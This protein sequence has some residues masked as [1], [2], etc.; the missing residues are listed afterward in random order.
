MKPDSRLKFDPSATSSTL[1]DQNDGLLADDF[2]YLEFIDEQEDGKSK[3]ELPSL[4]PI[5]CA[6]SMTAEGGRLVVSIW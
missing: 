2:G 1:G 3:E 6:E 5:S 4:G